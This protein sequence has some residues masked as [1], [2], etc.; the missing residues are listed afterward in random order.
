M[1]VLRHR[2]SLSLRGIVPQSPHLCYAH[3]MRF[4]PPAPLLLILSIIL[5]ACTAEVTPTAPATA[6]PLPVYSWP[7]DIVLAEPLWLADHLHDTDIRVIDLSEKP[8]YSLGHVPGAVHAY[9]QDLVERN[10]DTYGR[11]A[12]RPER[13]KTFGNLGIEPNTT[14]VVYDR[15]DNRAAARFAWAL[16]YAG[17]PTVRLLTGGLAGWA[18][19]GKP[20][21]TTAHTTPRV[22]YRDLPDESILINRCDMSRA[23]NDPNIVTLD[24]RTDREMAQTWDNTTQIGSIPNSHRLPWTMFI[25][26]PT[27]PVLHSPDDLRAVLASIGASPERTI[28]LYGTFS[29][30]AGIP[31][32]AL[33]ALGYP[34]V[35][36]YDGGWAEWGVSP[37]LVPARRQPCG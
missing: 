27:V 11:L 24:V 31:F 30:D 9:W 34:N 6:A 18:A 7:Y 36:L 25:R 32:F 19:A 14:V 12:G 10:S 15:N 13:E 33:K 5:T 23:A 21:E 35:R 1:T 17:H 20:V 8:Q 16:W 26:E 37:A 28:A 3:G 29:N 4:L 2:V 22:P